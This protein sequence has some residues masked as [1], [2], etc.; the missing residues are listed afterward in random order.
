MKQKL[1]D[2]WEDYIVWY[3][4]DKPIRWLQDQ[5]S[6]LYYGVRNLIRWLPFIWYDRNWASNYLL[7]M[8]AFKLDFMTDEF[9]RWNT[10]VGNEK[11]IKNMR[12]AAELLRSISN[13]EY[14]VYTHSRDFTMWDKEQREILN[15]A[16]LSEKRFHAMNNECWNLIKR[17]HRRWWD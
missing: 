3:L 7:D 2:I 14:E 6:G 15:E 16:A 11:D 9:T 5:R 1:L 12:R 10:Y 8:I 13:E 4:W 17:E